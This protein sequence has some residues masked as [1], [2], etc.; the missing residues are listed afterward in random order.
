M[1][2]RWVPGVFCSRHCR[3]QGEHGP[4]GVTRHAAATRRERPDR[5]TWVIHPS[6]RGVE[7]TGAVI[8]PA[9]VV[10]EANRAHGRALGPTDARYP[11]PSGTRTST[12]PGDC[13]AGRLRRR[14]QHA[15][16]QPSRQSRGAS[17]QEVVAFGPQPREPSTRGRRELAAWSLSR[18]GRVSSSGSRPCG[19][20]QPLPARAAGSSVRTP[21]TRGMAGASVPA[22]RSAC[23]R[24][25]TGDTPDTAGNRPVS[26]VRCRPGSAGARWRPDA[27]ADAA[28]TDT[29]SGARRRPTDGDSAVSGARRRPPDGRSPVSGARRRPIDANWAV[30][31]AVRRPPRDGRSRTTERSRTMGSPAVTEPSPS[32]ERARRPD[33]WRATDISCVAGA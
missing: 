20:V 8:A 15:A 18:I 14:R 22:R 26:A 21:G 31:S 12:A 6:P 32:S 13:A 33:G 4:P 9:T 24:V 10:A 7:P 27:P 2:K 5:V 1:C 23:G 30:S 25:A 28:A 3:H 29:P 19:A 17:P 11:G 16:R